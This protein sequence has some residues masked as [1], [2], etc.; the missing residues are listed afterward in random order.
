MQNWIAIIL[1]WCIYQTAPA[2]GHDW[3]ADNVGWDGK[4]H[5]STYITFSPRHLGPN[6]LPVPSLDDGLIENEHFLRASVQTHVTRGDFT[7]NPFLQFTYAMVPNR[8]SFDL[9]MTPV[10]YFSMSHEKRTERRT[11]HYLYGKQVAV[12]DVYLHTN[13]QLTRGRWD[14]RLRLG[15]RY[16]SSNMVGLARFTD[17]PGYYFDLNAARTIRETDSNRW[18]LAAMLGLYVWQTNSDVRFQND[19]ILFGLGLNYEH[20]DWHWGAHIRGYSGY[21]NN[22]DRPVV[23]KTHLRRSFNR[24]QA[25]TSY[26]VGLHDFAYHSVEL[27]VRYWLESKDGEN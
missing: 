6:A 1:L 16:A 3:W 9:F 20:N 14:T 10:E 12:G 5:W 21:L 15:F 25:E 17:S 26:Q 8:I 19:A 24:M 11:F 18:R 2:Q 27:G 13:V 7:L 22:G 23:W 4:A